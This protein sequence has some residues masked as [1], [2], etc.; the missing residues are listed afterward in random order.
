MKLVRYRGPYGAMEIDGNRLV[1]NG[2]P[3]ELSAEQIGRLKRMRRCEIEV[4]KPLGKRARAKPGLPPG[5]LI[6]QAGQI[7]T[8]HIE[9]SAPETGKEN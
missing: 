2:G 8:P 7:L 5:T 6:G 1:A 9:E 3:V 4:V